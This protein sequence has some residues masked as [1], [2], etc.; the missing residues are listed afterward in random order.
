MIRKLLM[1]LIAICMGVNAMAYD[2]KL[3]G[4]YYNIT[5]H[6]TSEVSVTYYTSYRL[7][8]WIAYSGNVVIP[9]TVTY[10]GQSY[11][12]TSIGSSAF[13]YCSSL[14]SVTIPNSVTSIGSE[15]F[16]G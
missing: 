16:Y 14:T 4:I 7:D 8:N 3:G 9:S 12:V 10:N 2:F 5:N 13:Q 1:V 11:S 6:S 15:A